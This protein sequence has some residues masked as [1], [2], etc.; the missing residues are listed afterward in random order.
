MAEIWLKSG[1]QI[2]LYFLKPLFLFSLDSILSP[3]K[4]NKWYR[5]KTSLI[6][7]LVF[8]TQ[9]LQLHQ[10]GGCNWTIW[11][12]QNIIII[13]CD[14]LME[15]GDGRAI[16]WMLR[17]RWWSWSNIVVAVSRVGGVLHLPWGETQSVCTLVHNTGLVCCS[18]CKARVRGHG[19]RNPCW[20]T[21]AAQ[22]EAWWTTKTSHWCV[23]VLREGS[24]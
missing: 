3:S 19:S 4:A 24:R 6:P 20:C 15:M 13:N 12:M 8:K 5:I 16:T 21:S 11:L 22:W 14:A 9:T 2:R 1:S 23:L 17:I 10:D 18:V 7:R